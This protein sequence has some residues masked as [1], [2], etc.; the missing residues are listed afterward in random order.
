MSVVP[1]IAKVALGHYFPPCGIYIDNDPPGTNT[2]VG[3]PE[4][5]ISG[6]TYWLTNYTNPEGT[7]A[8]W[9]PSATW[10]KDNFVQP[11][12]Y[13]G[14][15]YRRSLPASGNAVAGT[16]EPVWP[17]VNGGT[18]VD[19]GCTWIYEGAVPDFSDN[20]GEMRDIPSDSLA[21]YDN[22]PG[23]FVPKSGGAAQP[24]WRL[25]KARVEIDNMVASGLGGAAI[26]VLGITTG[27]PDTDGNWQRSRAIMQAA[28]QYAI[29]TG[30]T[31]VVVPQLDMSGG[32]ATATQAQVLAAIAAFAA[33]TSTWRVMFGGQSCIVVMP[34]GAETKTPAFW[35]GV[36]DAQQTLG[37]PIVLI[38]T[39]INY[40][41][42]WNAFYTGMTSGLGGFCHWGSRS[43]AANVVGASDS[44]HPTMTRAQNAHSLGLWW[45][46]PVSWQDA[47]ERS[48]KYSE[49]L[50]PLNLQRTLQIAADA[51]G[52]LVPTWNDQSEGSGV[53]RSQLKGR[54]VEILLARGLYYWTYGV[55]MPNDDSLHIMH[56]NHR[57]AAVPTWVGYAGNSA[58]Y[59]VPDASSS[60]PVDLV[61]F[62]SFLKAA[63]SVTANIAGTPHTYAA[64]AGEFWTSYASPVSGSISATVTR[65]GHTDTL[66]SPHTV[67]ASPLVQSFQY[68]AAT[69]VLSLGGTTAMQADRQ[70]LRLETYK[71]RLGRRV[72]ESV[73]DLE[74]A[75][76]NVTSLANGLACITYFYAEKTEVITNFTMFAGVAQAGA[77]YG[78]VGFY[79][80]DETT[81]DVI[82]GAPVAQY[83]GTD[84]FSSSATTGLNKSFA[85]SWAKQR[86]QLYAWLPLWVGATTQPTIAGMQVNPPGMAYA[87]LPRASGQLT[88]LSTLPATFTEASVLAAGQNNR[89][90]QLLLLP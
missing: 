68:R 50:G 15:K 74:S 57:V 23:T 13:T 70:Q 85:A 19:G 72:G 88:G 61:Y 83:V 8:R 1:P 38:P 49:S 17:T 69:A 80:I 46:Q 56:R 9:R 42:Y 10:G 67:V 18:V 43:P 89:R 47:R 53:Q 34:Y 22:T 24:N 78:A 11:K 32:G 63:G 62:G 25:T 66:A 3:Y 37:V 28:D 87:G 21:G 77:T 41:A 36:V 27:L 6:D 58:N 40:G 54:S 60:A 29:D 39:F 76:T 35:Q 81:G 73:L 52:I 5:G 7:T 79:A 71:R 14:R 86:G 59:A 2:A 4:Y 16:V 45:F 12:V 48:N 20:G 84:V 55:N 65:N 26:N 82:G 31:F 44:S 64:P 51:D 33:Y 75:N 90:L 30:K